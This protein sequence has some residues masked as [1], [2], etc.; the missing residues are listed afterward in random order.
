[1]YSLPPVEYLK[2]PFFAILVVPLSEYPRV[3]FCFIQKDIDKISIL[4]YYKNTVCG[5]I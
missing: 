2:V 3:V 5:I 4:V 1:M